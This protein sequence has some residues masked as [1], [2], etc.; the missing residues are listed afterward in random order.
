MKVLVIG[1]SGATGVLS[2]QK[3]L[4]AGHDVTAFARTEASIKTQ[5]PKLKI[6]LGNVKDAAA[7]DKAV[8]GQD[9]VFSVFGPRELKK[10]DAQEQF[11]KNIVAS[12]KK[13][14]VKKLVNLSAWGAGDSRQ[15]MTFIFSIIRATM[16]KNIFDDKDRGEILLANSG[17]DYVSVRPGQLSNGKPRK[18]PVKASLDPKGIEGK[19]DRED[20][21]TFMVA[22]LTDSTW[23]GKSPLIGY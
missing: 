19:L 6:A 15:H 17:L 9:A 10:D 3:L 18:T 21:A 7:L 4:D 2:V 1:A 13:H 11:M 20:L 23:N 12:M 5:H 8:E 16:L 22:Q 14:G